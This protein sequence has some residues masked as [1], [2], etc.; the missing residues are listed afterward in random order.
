MGSLRSSLMKQR[1][2]FLVLADVSVLLVALLLACF[3]RFDEFFPNG[4]SQFPDLMRWMQIDL[5]LTPLVFYFFGLYRSSWRYASISDLVRIVQGVVV[6]TVAVVFLFFGLGLSSLPRS[7]VAMDAVLL[8]L[9]IGGLRMAT[10][11]HGEMRRRRIGGRPVLIV[12]AG[13]SGEM[14]VRE[15]RRRVDLDYQPIGFVDDD[16]E[17]HGMYIHGLPVL[18]GREDIPEII[19]SRNVKEVIVAIPSA[20]AKDLREIKSRCGDGTVR[21]KAVPAVSE[22]LD[23]GGGLRQIRDVRVEDLLGREAVVLDAEAIRR[24]ITGSPILVTGG[25]GSIGREM[26]RQLAGLN[27]SCLILVDRSE[28]NLFAIGQDLSNLAPELEVVYCIGDVQDEARMREVMQRYRPHVI[29][30]AAAYKHVPM[31]EFNVVEAISNN[32]FGSYLMARLAAE[33]EVARFVLISTDKAVNPTSIMGKTK[34]VGELILQGM[35]G[36]KT[37]FMSVRFG[38]V[39]GSDGSVVPIFRDQIASGGPVTVTHPE[40]TRY[41]MTIPEAVQL[42]MQAGSMGRGGEIFMLDMGTPVR[43]VDLARNMIELSGLRPKVEIEIVFT[44]LRPGEKLHEELHT[45]EEGTQ[46]TSHEKIVVLGTSPVPL[47]P[48]EA[49]LQAL[50]GCLKVRDPE[51]LASRLTELVEAYS[52]QPGGPDRGAAPESGKTRYREAYT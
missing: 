2:A 10:R 19:R 15:M 23:G 43:I 32:V 26:A 11:V 33:H 21:L 36:G 39:L 18:G 42:V 30:H 52:P 17:K 50:R 4:R 25:G 49:A 8:V 5:L 51:E 3:L 27:P 40:A 38:N 1:R 9:L 28:N 29:Y 34:R 35:N 47:P 37:R 12:G 16:N 13:E 45:V 48:L 24:D 14:I 7:V 6:R 44:G 46:P 22:M 41:F 20:S 31:M